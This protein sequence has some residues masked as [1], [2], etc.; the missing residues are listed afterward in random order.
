L[1]HTYEAL[2]N[3]EILILHLRKGKRF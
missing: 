3:S 1:H 2:E